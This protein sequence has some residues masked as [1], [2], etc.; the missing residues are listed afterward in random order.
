MKSFKEILIEEEVSNGIGKGHI[1]TDKEEFKTLP[2]DTDHIH[3]LD[4]NSDGD[5]K[6]LGTK[7]DVEAHTHKIEKWVVLESHEHTHKID[8]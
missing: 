3:T 7:G 2:D 8:K 4:V 1:Q 5:G 6:T